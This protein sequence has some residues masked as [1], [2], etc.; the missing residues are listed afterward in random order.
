MK[1]LAGALLIPF[2]AAPTFASEPRSKEPRI[3]RI[4]GSA[5]F[6]GE[7]TFID[8]DNR[9]DN[10]GGF[11]DQYLW[12][13]NRGS[14]VPVELGIRDG[15]LDL[16][17]AGDTPLLQARLRSSTSNLGVSGSQVDDPFFNQHIDVQGRER[18]IHL[19]LGYDRI[20]TEQLRRSLREP[21]RPPMRPG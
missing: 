17:G 11:F 9:D 14:S 10:R 2:L 8:G 5:T 19:D 13:P 12:K 7:Y 18:G 20:R 6:I 16:I 3:E 21:K 1:G 15:S 4:D